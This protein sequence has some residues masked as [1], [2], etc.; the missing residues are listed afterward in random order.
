MW[1]LA[2]KMLQTL[3]WEELGDGEGIVPECY[4]LSFGVDLAAC[5][6]KVEIYCRWY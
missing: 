2:G 1:K 4:L 3:P 6:E 5:K